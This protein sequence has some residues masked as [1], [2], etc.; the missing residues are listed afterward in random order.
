MKRERHGYGHGSGWIK[1]HETII[2][3]IMHDSHY[4]NM[5]PFEEEG[6]LADVGVSAPSSPP[7]PRVPPSPRACACICAPI[8]W[9]MLRAFPSLLVLNML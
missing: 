7:S 5:P 2:R 8:T 6:E 3:R 4:L 9:A 1:D